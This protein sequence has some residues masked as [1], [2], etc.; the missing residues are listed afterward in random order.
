M[1]KR[2]AVVPEALLGDAPRHQTDSKRPR[3]GWQAAVSVPSFSADHQ[4]AC[5][6]ASYYNEPLSG[7]DIIIRLAHKD[8]KW[9]AI[10]YDVIWIH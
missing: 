9:K 7:G 2:H 8:G 1:A 6:Y 5:I 4:N 3:N 10:D